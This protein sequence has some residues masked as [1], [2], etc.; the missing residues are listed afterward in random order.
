MDRADQRPVL[1]FWPKVTVA[2]QRVV[3]C[4]GQRLREQARALVIGWKPPNWKEWNGESSVDAVIDLQMLGAG[5]VYRRLFNLGQYRSV[6]IPTAAYSQVSIFATCV[7]SGWELRA[8]VAS[9][10]ANEGRHEP[11]VYAQFI[12][13]TAQRAVP[14]GAK[15]VTAAVN[16]PGWTWRAYTGGPVAIA[17]A[18]TGA[19]PATVKGTTYQNSVTPLSLSWEIEL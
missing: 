13:G 10:R 19:T 9:E 15:S 17:N 18:L 16:D 6:E 7:E 11:V 14:F 3:L 4:D 5:M 2:N 12:T 1:D 8:F